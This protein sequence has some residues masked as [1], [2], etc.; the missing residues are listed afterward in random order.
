MK[1]ITPYERELFFQVM[2]DH[3]QACMPLYLMRRACALS[4]ETDFIETLK[5]LKRNNIRGVEFVAWFNSK[6]GAINATA[7]ARRSILR[8]LETRS[9]FSKGLT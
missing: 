5:W 6:G 4:R 9:M 1:P 2:N 3:S 7:V 8:D